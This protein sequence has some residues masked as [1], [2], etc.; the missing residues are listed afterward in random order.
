MIDRL[1]LGISRTLLLGSA[2]ALALMMVILCW[3]VL[4][5]YLLGNSPAWAEQSAL[6]L[7]IWMT[8]LGT[9]S[10]IA[11]GFH[12]RIAEGVTSL[13]PPWHS[14]AVAV[15]NLLI[16]LAGMMILWFGVVL[17]TETWNNAVPTLPLSRGMVYIV[18]PISGLLIALFA[19]H[20]L[21]RGEETGGSLGS[22]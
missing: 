11:S 20:H 16:M 1:V 5:R 13:P 19:C 15:A 4:A 10:G 2:I 22:A 12:I 3:Q 17:V 21:V 6:L 8:F 18:I 9:A 7:M 14:R